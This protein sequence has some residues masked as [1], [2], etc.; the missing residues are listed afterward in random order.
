MRDL[1]H[2]AARPRRCVLISQLPRTALPDDVRRLGDRGALAGLE[3]FRTPHLA[4]TGS[5]LA[6]VAPGVDAR[7]F[8]AAAHARLLG[9]QRLTA[10]TVRG[11][12][13]HRH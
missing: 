1:A 7:G 2:A 11:A 13:H 12:A 4:P 8:A 6:L 5:A 3:F 9:G 10:R